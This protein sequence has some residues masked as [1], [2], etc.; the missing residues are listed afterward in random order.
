MATTYTKQQARALCAKCLEAKGLDEAASVLESEAEHLLAEIETRGLRTEK[1]GEL[2]GIDWVRYLQKLARGLR[3]GRAAFKVFAKGNSKLPFYS[4][5]ELP[6]FT[7]PGAGECLKF[8]YSFTAWRYPAAFMR[9]LQNTLFMR[10]KRSV[11]AEAF[12]L[13]PLAA[14]EGRVTLRL[15]VDGDFRDMTTLAFW[16][17]MLKQRPEVQCYGYSKSWKLFESWEKQGLPFP[18]NYTLNLSSGSRYAQDRELIRVVKG[19]ACTRGE[20]V[21]V[22][23][24]GKF[25]KG[26]ARFA[27]KG[28]HAAVRTAGRKFIESPR[29]FSCPGQCGSCLPSGKHAC[30][31]RDFLVTIAIAEHN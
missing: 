14:G 30:G 25:A 17:S 26:F 11:I 3:A 10:F 4:Y 16:M 7:C 20:F 6:E 27:D 13:I 23:A 9:Q 1:S 28:Y 15:Y 29:V 24:P 12:R 2:A 22:K 31:Q 21:A 5:S 19:L 8:C 18:S